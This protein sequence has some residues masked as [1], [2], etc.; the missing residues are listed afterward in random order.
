MEKTRVVRGKKTR[1]V[2]GEENRE[3][4]MTRVVRWEVPMTRVVS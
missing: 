4:P 3:E 2:G 1:V